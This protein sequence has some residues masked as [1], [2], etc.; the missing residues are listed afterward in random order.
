MSENKI[1]PATPAHLIELRKN[2]RPADR[3]EMLNYGGC[4]RRLLWQTYHDTLEPKAVLVDGKVAGV[5]GCI[6]TVIGMVGKPWWLS[7]P[8]ADAYPIPL[9][10]L[11][12]Q[13]VRKMLE[14]YDMLENWVDSTYD[15]SIRLMKIIGFN[16]D[17]PMPY[18]PNGHP[19][20]RFWMRA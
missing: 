3:Q 4:M 6:G 5:F 16:V 17:P 11:Y 15:K 20:C 14:N 8:I 10:L 18:G 12:R 2:M 13:E 1:V 9:A 19:F 7:T